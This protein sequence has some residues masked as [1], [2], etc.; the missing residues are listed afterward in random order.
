MDSGLPTMS[1]A[2][3]TVRRAGQSAHFD[4]PV[5]IDLDGRARIALPKV[6]PQHASDC[7]QL[8]VELDELLMS[9]GAA[10]AEHR[11]RQGGAA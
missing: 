11:N 6:A 1:R 8:I 9:L 4:L 10:V 2:H 5:W 3:A 7:D